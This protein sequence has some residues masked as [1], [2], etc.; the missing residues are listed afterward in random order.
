MIGL[1]L[2]VADISEGEERLSAAETA[3]KLAQSGIV[4]NREGA[5]GMK[6]AGETLDTKD[7]VDKDGVDV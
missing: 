4:G 7:D 5:R 3:G 6:G 1:F 2:A